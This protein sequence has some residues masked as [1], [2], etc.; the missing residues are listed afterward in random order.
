MGAVLLLIGVAILY[1][2]AYNTYGKFLARKIF[3][4]N[5]NRVCPSKELQDDHDYVPTRREILFGH[6]FTS[7]AGTGPIV[8]PAIAVIWGWLPALLWIIFGSIFMGAVH[9]FGS[10]IV[11]VRR[12]GRSIGDVVGDMVNHRIR[13]LFL[14]IIFFLLWIF[15]AILGMVIAIAF[16]LYPAAVFPVWFEIPIAIVLGFLLYRKGLSGW[17]CSVIAVAIMYVTVIA[18]AYWP[19][20]MPTFQAINASGQVVAVFDPLMIWVICF[21]VYAY[22]ASTLPV[23]TLLQPRDYINSHQ[24]FIAL[25]LLI[26]GVFAA[27]PEIVAPAVNL[28]PEGA[29]PLFPLL[30]ITVACGAISG[31]H[32]TVSSGTS[33]K[34]CASESDTLS[35]GYGG[36]L[37]EGFLAVLVI[38]ACVAGIGMGMEKTGN[39]LSGVE[40]YSHHYSSWKAAGGLS[41]KLSAFVIGSSNMI[42]CLG[43]PMKISIAVM[44]VLV[45]SFAATSLDSAT[46]IQRYIVSEIAR[47]CR[48]PG[49]AGKHPATLIAVATAFGLAFHNGSGNGAL[50][51]W[52]LFGCVNQLVAALALLAITIYLAQRKSPVW[53]SLLPMVI[54]VALTVWAMIYNLWNYIEKHQL[55][56]FV[57]GACIVILELWM[58]FESV[59][60][61]KKTYF[62]HAGDDIPE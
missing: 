48:V 13:M 14:L 45:V 43:I 7:I 61:L 28:S 2:I 3:R 21:L 20:E 12:Q 34:Q 54:M 32:A 31:F 35:V 26:L 53:V 22:I 56:L 4:L 19:L 16:D 39:M 62:K 15:I 42:S 46:R 27:R 59:L 50:T 38:I 11:S 33:S 25:G 10:L 17:W 5:P 41:S 52:P 37:L 24:L 8:G 29:P 47:F 55:L 58:I 60:V 44:G 57:V 30:F 40:A 51:L 9:D 23:Q 49:L 6:H 1:L 18:G 36:M